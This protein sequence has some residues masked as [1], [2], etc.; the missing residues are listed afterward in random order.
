MYGDPSQIRVHRV[1]LNFNDNEADLINAWVKY[2][3]QEKAAF[4]R[5]MLLE[6]ARLDMGL[7]GSGAIIAA[8]AAQPRL[9]RS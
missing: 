7:D 8:E 5:E 4:L 1:G 6:Q 3:G 9:F 2:S